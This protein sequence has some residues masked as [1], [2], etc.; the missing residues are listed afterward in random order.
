M[1]CA[2][3]MRG[4]RSMARQIDGCAC[5]GPDRTK[6]YSPSLVNL[7]ITPG[8]IATRHSPGRVSFSTAI[9]TAMT[10]PYASMT[11]FSAWVFAAWPKVS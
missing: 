8:A 11:T 9:R 3:P 10:L 2:R 6:T 7:S 1:A 4:T 5:T